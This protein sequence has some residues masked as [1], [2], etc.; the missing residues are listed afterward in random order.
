MN[1]KIVIAGVLVAVAVVAVAVFA[2]IYLAPHGGGVGNGG[3]NSKCDVKSGQ[4]SAFFQQKCN[5]TE[6]GWVCY[7]DDTQTSDLYGEKCEQNGGMW[8]C[9]GFCMQDY[10][11]TCECPYAD[12]GKE[13]TN[14]QQCIGKCVVDTGYVA[15]KYPHNTRDDVINCG[16]FCKG[17][18]S[19]YPLG[20]CDW[21]YEVNDGKLEN[22]AQIF[23]D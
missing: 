11:R 12:A 10:P 3:N 8:D 15:E 13:C 4:L 19:A 22:H 1:E 6:V 2:V 16:F 9:S 14:S 7:F 20:F 21:Y 17:N 23:C 5:E 18:C